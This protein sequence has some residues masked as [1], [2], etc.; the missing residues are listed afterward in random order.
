M[1]FLHA[2]LSVLGLTT[3]VI[4]SVS[5]HNIIPLVEAGA[6]A[7]GADAFNP[8]A[9]IEFT[10][11]FLGG[12]GL[13]FGL[14]LAF[15]AQKFAVKIDPKVE[16]VRNALPGANCGACG[17]AGCQ[18]YAEAVVGKQEIA[19]NLCAPGKSSVA[20]QVAFITGKK[21]EKTE[22]KFARIMCQGGCSKAVKR[23]VYEG[24]KDCRAAILAGGG[25]KACQYGCLGYGT[26]EKAC[27][28]GAITMTE[29][30][31][32]YVDI[33]KCTGCGKCAT[34]CPVKVIEILPGSKEV[35]V[36]C[37]SRDK[38]VE[39]RKNCQVGC[40][41]CG[42]CVKTCPFEAMT[43]ENN[44]ARVDIEKCKVCG[45]CERKCPTG[46]IRDFIP[47]RPKANI[48]PNCI[49]CTICAKA[50][51]VDAISGELKKMHTVDRSRCIGCGICAAKCPV[52]AI[53]GTFN[54]PEIMAAAKA[55]KAAKAAAPAA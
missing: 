16:Q 35:L 7:G 12:L 2:V 50:C 38:G 33:T 9:V 27:P 31:L 1:T 45:L 17:F 25:D 54:A 46:A 53:D 30:S 55:K 32:P 28:F 36:A 24:V 39:T 8:V 10:L 20:E 22:P 23:F 40:I 14:G 34:A 21:A 47:E 5:P 41:A 6:K 48:L 4:R 11:I 3:E 51:P 19:P 43:L 37:H 29:D 26:C 15:A 13:I 42:I 52:Q 44:L 18:G 49:G